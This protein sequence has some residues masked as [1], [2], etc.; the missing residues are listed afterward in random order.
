MI[1]WKGQNKNLHAL[2]EVTSTVGATALTAGFILTASGIITTSTAFIVLPYLIPA[3]CIQ[4]SISYVA[5]ALTFAE[6]KQRVPVAMNACISISMIAV[7]F[8]RLL[9]SYAAKNCSDF[10][11]TT[12]CLFLGIIALLD[13]RRAYLAL[14]I[15]KE[16]IDCGRI[17]EHNPY[18]IA[19]I[20]DRK[21]TLRLSLVRAVSWFIVAAGVTWFSP[22]A[23]AGGLVTITGTHLYNNRASFFGSKPQAIALAN[24]ENAP[25]SS[26]EHNTIHFS[27]ME[28][29]KINSQCL[30]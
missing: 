9:P 27:F 22:V 30:A 1:T 2:A 12:S 26:F 16:D 10:D 14:Q 4:L 7:S 28:R 6:K 3:V 23:I 29:M 21:E 8:I 18:W 15:I 11:I 24:H 19:V 17:S 25:N 13:A 20:A 5:D